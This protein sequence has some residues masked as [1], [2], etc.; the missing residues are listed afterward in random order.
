[1]LTLSV[2][3][4]YSV[5]VKARNDTSANWAIHA[6]MDTDMFDKVPA[7]L[8]P[9]ITSSIMYSSSASL[10]NSGFIDEYSD[11]NDT[12]LV[13]VDVIPMFPPATK[14]IELEASNV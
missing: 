4:R 2:A 3:Q 10:T 5:L 1:M 14:T 13:P 6:N 11:V 7:A 9:N 8:N 12:A